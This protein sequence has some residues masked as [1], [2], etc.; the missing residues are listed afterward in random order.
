MAFIYLLQ[1]SPAFFISFCSIV[2]VMVGSF[3]NVVIYR[4][5]KMLQREW[6]QQCAQL[7]GETAEV[8]AK[9][10]AEAAES[11]EAYNIVTPRSACPHCGH[12]IT[13]LENIPIAS[14]VVLGGRCTQCRASISARYPAIELLTGLISGFI[15]WH[16]GYSVAAFA[17]LAFVWPMIAVAF[18]DMDTQLLPDDITL[19]L[20]WGGLLINLGDVFTDIH[21]AVIGAVAGYLVLWL[22]YWCY[23]LMS[24]KEGMGRGDFKLL[25]VIGAWLGW[26]M[27]PLVILFSSMVGTMVGVGLIVTAK[28]GRHTPIPFGPYL[29]GGGLVALFWGNPLNRAYFELF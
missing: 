24:G 21:S 28:R 3:L 7:R 27:L 14:Y 12:Q 19:P 13:V 8:A 17:A 22:V 5:P 2:G 25:A 20:L 26:Q 29:V 10:A 6:Q 16:Y 1:N 11:A 23:K 15:A 9:V 4:L 18:I